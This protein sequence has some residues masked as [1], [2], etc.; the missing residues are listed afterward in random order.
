MFRFL[1]GGLFL[2]FVSTVAFA[3]TAKTSYQQAEQ[4]RIQFIKT[5]ADNYPKLAQ[6]LALYAKACASKHARACWKVGFLLETYPKGRDDYAKQLKLPPFAKKTDK[7]LSPRLWY[8]RGCSLRLGDACFYTYRG[9]AKQDSRRASLLLKRACRFKS[10]EAC[11]HLYLKRKAVWAKSKAL[12]KRTRTRRQR[13]TYRFSRKIFR[14][15]NA[16]C[17]RGVAKDCYAM[18]HLHFKGIF[19]LK[20]PKVAY[21][22]F[23]RACALNLAE[24]C[25]Y[26][27]VI[28]GGGLGVKQDFK[29]ARA[30]HQKA[31]QLHSMDGCVHFGGM[32]FRGLGGEK[33]L[34][35]AR[36][37]FRNACMN[38][39]AQACLLL[40]EMML[41]GEGGD[42]D[43]KAGFRTYKRA[44]KL[45]HTVGCQRVREIQKYM[46]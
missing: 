23:T 17:Q 6:A 31:C 14:F 29:A 10:G 43:L 27:G 37:Q 38:D 22:V 24:A 20:Q 2:L 44:C 39:H 35:E 33:D 40:G 9:L 41:R 46:K 21:R 34:M 36:R 1:F 4:I 8:T 45:K 25:D 13:E 15:F 12:S 5:Q 26:L 16:A 42:R 19:G 7:P 18:G 28:V 32:V 30:F 3:S 11:Y